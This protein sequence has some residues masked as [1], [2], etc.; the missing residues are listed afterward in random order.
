MRL[1]DTNNLDA[2]LNRDS[3]IMSNVDENSN[4]DDGFKMKEES[5]KKKDVALFIGEVTKPYGDIGDSD[6][7]NKSS[8]ATSKRS[9]VTNH[10][11]TYQKA[12]DEELTQIGAVL[13]ALLN[14]IG[15]WTSETKM[16]RT[17]SNLK[18]NQ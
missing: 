2:Y 11:I 6:P 14:I 5:P 18:E 16:T 10:K 1:S 4:S 9:S 17:F 3:N 7:R 8:K 15:I 12:A 13:Y